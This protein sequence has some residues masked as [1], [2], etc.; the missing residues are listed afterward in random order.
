[1]CLLIYSFIYDSYLF[2]RGINFETRADEMKQQGMASGMEARRRI[3][4]DP[5]IPAADK[6]SAGAG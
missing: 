1:M 6:R 3:A 5:P 4:L 2:K